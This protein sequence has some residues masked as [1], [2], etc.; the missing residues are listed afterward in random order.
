VAEYK[1]G[2]VKGEE[3]TDLQKIG[4]PNYEGVSILRS[5]TWRR[6]HLEVE[7]G[8]Y[9]VANSCALIATVIGRRGYGTSRL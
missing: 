1:V 4:L 5:K 8:T 3:T 9:L 6:L 7:P 2:R